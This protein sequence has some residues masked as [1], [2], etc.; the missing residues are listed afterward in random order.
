MKS[1]K[2]LAHNVTDTD[3]RTQNGSAH[4]RVF[5]IFKRQFWTTEQDEKSKEN[6]CIFYFFSVRF[7]FNQTYF[8]IDA[9][10]TLLPW[11]PWCVASKSVCYSLTRS[12]VST[13]FLFRA[14]YHRRCFVWRPL[15]LFSFGVCI[16]N[17]TV[18]C[19]HACKTARGRGRVLPDS[20]TRGVCIMLEKLKEWSMSSEWNC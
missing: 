3:W 5:V 8:C 2:W 13:L 9:A 1:R 11:L 7:P 14:L 10:K 4:G 16:L 12:L 20:F 15:K 6:H 19:L 18:V 17:D